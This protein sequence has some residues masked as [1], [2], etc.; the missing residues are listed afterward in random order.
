MC[1]PKFVQTLL[2]DLSVKDGE[3]LKLTCIVKGD[4]EPNITWS[5]NNEVKKIEIILYLNFVKYSFLFF[6]CIS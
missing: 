4:P 6:F 1:T 5:K 2:G 3:A